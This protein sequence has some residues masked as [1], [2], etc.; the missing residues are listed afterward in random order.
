MPKPWLA[1]GLR[2]A[3]DPKPPAYVLLLAAPGRPLKPNA[4]GIPEPT[5][6][7]QSPLQ[8][9]QATLMLVPALAMNLRG[10]RLGAYYDRFFLLPQSRLT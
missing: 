3:G 2:P 8:V 4:F 7:A 1:V 10:H 5:P 9:D 6:A